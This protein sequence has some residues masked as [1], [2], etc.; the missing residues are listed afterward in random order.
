[1]PFFYCT[2][3][4]S[5]HFLIIWIMITIISYVYTDTHT[6]TCMLTR[7]TREGW[8]LL[9]VETEVNGVGTQRVKITKVLPW[10]GSLDL[11]CWYKR[12]L[13]QYKIYFFP[14]VHYFNIC[15]PI[16]QQPEH[17]SRAGQPVSECVSLLRT[18]PQPTPF[19]AILSSEGILTSEDD[20]TKA[21][22]PR[23]YSLSFVCILSSLQSSHASSCP[24]D[25]ILCM[26]WDTVPNS[27]N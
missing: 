16:A 13:S 3:C 7:E 1:M 12:L 9:T 27:S 4:F 21:F 24:C 19:P 5:Q 17:C 2:E 11:S 8:P 15:V 23:M 20:E 14:S 22:I 26:A 10:D 25:I 18:T 6:R